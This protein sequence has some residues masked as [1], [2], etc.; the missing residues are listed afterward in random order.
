MTSDHVERLIQAADAPLEPRRQFADDL[1]DHLLEQLTVAQSG[2]EGETTDMSTAIAFPA[3]SGTLTPS[4]SE[5]KPSTSIGPARKPT[6]MT[7]LATAALLVLALV[8]GLYAAG[9]PLNAVLINQSSPGVE[10][11][12]IAQ[13]EA[14]TDESDYSTTFTGISRIVI[15]PGESLESGPDTYYG[16]GLFLFE[17]ES[18]TL[19]IESVGAVEFLI[20]GADRGTPMPEGGDGDLKAGDRAVLWPET[21]TTW[22][23]DGSESA[24]ILIAAVGEVTETAS[25]VDQVDLVKSFSAIWPEPP[26][27]YSLHRLTFESGASLPVAEL[28]GLM[29][30]G[31][32]SGEIGVPLSNGEGNPDRERSFDSREG[33]VVSDWDLAETGDL[34]NSGSE[35]AVIYVLLGESIDMQA[36]PES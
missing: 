30:I 18:G 20:D 35:P 11:E 24:V 23:N 25:D 31:V 16:D 10:N 36:T 1:L 33:F 29:M 5:I 12:L 28:P 2:N 19:A 26:A 34:R 17:V 15:E 7:L 21:V 32:D 22:R 4:P 8:G 14:E 3:N 9:V 27:T 13:A 6:V